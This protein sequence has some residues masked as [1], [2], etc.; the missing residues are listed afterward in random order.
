M[1]GIYG[2]KQNL[3]GAN[4]KSF[5]ELVGMVEAQKKDVV[6]ADAGNKSAGTRLRVAMMAIA[7]QAKAVKDESLTYSKAK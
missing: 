6:L 1:S 7:K 3:E 4:M 2:F 5:D